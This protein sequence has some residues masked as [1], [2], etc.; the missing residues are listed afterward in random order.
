MTRGLPREADQD[1][2]EGENNYEMSSVYENS[3]SCH[4]GIVSDHRFDGE[5]NTMSNAGQVMLM[6]QGQ[7]HKL[8]ATV[9]SSDDLASVWKDGEWNQLHLIARGYTFI[10]IING[11]VLTVNVDDDASKRQSKGIIALQVEGTNMRASFRNI[12]LKTL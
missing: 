7:S 3:Q 4:G 2:Q 8:L 12:W 6:S 1:N 9:G 5:R 11:R 10:H